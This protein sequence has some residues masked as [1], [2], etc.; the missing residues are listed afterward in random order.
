MLLTVLALVGPLFGLILI[1]F[2]AHRRAW[3]PA[4]SS[5][6]LNAYVVHLGLPAVLFRVLAETDTRELW[7]PG[8]LLATG[9][10]MAILFAVI[11]VV[12]RRQGFPLAEAGLD[13]MIASYPNTGFMGIPLCLAAFGPTGALAAAIAAAIPVTIV[14]AVTIMIIEFDI[15]RDHALPAALAK[16]ARQIISNPLVLW[17]VLGTFWHATGLA[18]P[19]PV[20]TIVNLLADSASPCALV[21]IGLFLAES[22]HTGGHGR[23][24]LLVGIKLFIQPALAALVTLVLV[25]TPPVWASAAI[26]LAA[27]PTGVGPFMI[28]THYG[29]DNSIPARAI[30]A[31][32]VLSL[33]TLT[34][35]L[36]LLGRGA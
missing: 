27:L 9:G 32:T 1:G 16:T 28:A 22:S 19:T 18:L 24:G 3:L 7:Q 10:S 5:G 30:F 11:L 35:L 17:P 36:V 31:S 6:A 21:N 14:F 4:G 26:V 23:I 34:L 13:G 20:H 25:P 8:F 2:I 12:R 29:R 33:V 15:H